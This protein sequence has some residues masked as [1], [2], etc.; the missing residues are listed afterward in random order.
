[1][2]LPLLEKQVLT[3]PLRRLSIKK[4]AAQK[5]Q[6]RA[7]SPESSDFAS[8]HHSAKTNEFKGFP[9][10]SRSGHFGEF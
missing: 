2:L 10:L 4:L 3:T 1:V 6:R 5:E 9:F 7:T 8:S